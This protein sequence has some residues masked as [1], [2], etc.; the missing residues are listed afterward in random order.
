MKKIRLILAITCM[1]FSCTACDVKEQLP[2]MYIKA[3]ELTDEELNLIAL[4]GGDDIADK[5]AIYDFKLDDRI[6]AIQINIYELK[7]AEWKMISG[8]SSRTFG[9]IDG[10]MAISTDNIA[11]G[12]R[13]TLQ[14]ENKKG[15]N[16]YITEISKEQ[17]N[18]GIGTSKL[19]SMEEIEY[20]KEIPLVIQVQTNKNGMRLYDVEY[21]NQ[22][23]EYAKLDYEHVYA[24]TIMFSK[25]SIN[26]L[27]NIY[28]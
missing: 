13:I 23:E 25:K 1:L 9:D 19:T 20:E 4:V 28:K 26:E 12:C 5:Q 3:T 24:V 22:P 7:D 14:S 17:E 27:D 11:K 21:F 8:G 6:K 15:S 2:N 10:R 18:M 16:S